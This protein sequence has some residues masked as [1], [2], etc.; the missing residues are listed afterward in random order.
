[1]QI[2]NGVYLTFLVLISWAKNFGG[3]WFVAFCKFHAS[4]LKFNNFRRP[5]S[6]LKEY[7]SSRPWWPGDFFKKQKSD[8]CTVFCCLYIGCLIGGILSDNVENELLIF[9]VQELSPPII[10]R[11]CQT[12]FKK[13]NWKTMN[14]ETSPGKLSLIYKLQQLPHLA[15]IYIKCWNPLNWHW[16]SLT[17]AC[18]GNLV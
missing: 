16:L 6:H 5:P 7:T 4:E 3:L 11:A 2:G 17:K 8:I 10:F 15:N 1:M 14:L 9:L 18:W 12:S 13:Q